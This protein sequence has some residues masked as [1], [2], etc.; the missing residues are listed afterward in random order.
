MEKRTVLKGALVTALAITAG[1]AQ[2]FEIKGIYVDKPVN[3]DQ[4]KAVGYTVG[5]FS[6]ACERGDRIWPVNASFLDG[7]SV[8]MITQSE[9]RIVM[10]V[11]VRN[12]PFTDA[13]DALSVKYGKPSIKNSVIQNRMGASFEQIEATWKD[14]AE[15]LYLAKHGSELNKPILILTGSESGRDALK[16]NQQKAQKGAGNL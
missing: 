4:I 12:F 5:S 8:V 11:Q 1:H 16:Q 7:K 3:C 15:E 9:D 14:G 10:S 6:G 2:T 13:L